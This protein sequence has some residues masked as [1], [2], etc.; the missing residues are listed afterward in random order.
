MFL[1]FLTTTI[2][3]SIQPLPILQPSTFDVLINLLQ[4]SCKQFDNS[5]KT[6]LNFFLKMLLSVVKMFLYY[7][8]RGSYKKKLK[9]DLQGEETLAFPFIIFLLTSDK[10]KN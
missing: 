9:S 6:K 1:C 10:N 8:Q 7:S 2:F 3:C 4:V 5:D